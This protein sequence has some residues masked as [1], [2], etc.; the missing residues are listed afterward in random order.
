[1]WQRRSRVHM[2]GKLGIPGWL[3]GDAGDDHLKGDGGNDAC[4]R[5]G[6]GDSA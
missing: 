1:M 4:A 2:A 6:P 3:Y 5:H